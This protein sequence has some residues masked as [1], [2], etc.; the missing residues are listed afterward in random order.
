MRFYVA[1]LLLKLFFASIAPIY[2]YLSWISLTVSVFSLSIIAATPGYPESMLLLNW[3]CTNKLADNSWLTSIMA[4][5]SSV[6]KLA[7]SLLAKPE[8]PS[9][10]G[11]LPVVTYLFSWLLAPAA[12]ALRSSPLPLS[13]SRLVP[14]SKIVSSPKFF[15]EEEDEARGIAGSPLESYLK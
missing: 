5:S 12:A 14:D 4:Q 13:F 3:F 9:L 6:V 7:A 15:F 2:L 1:V 11:T 8:S 10:P